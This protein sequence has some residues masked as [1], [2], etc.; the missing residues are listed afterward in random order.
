MS[1]CKLEPIHL[2]MT[3]LKWDLLSSSFILERPL[4]SGWSSSRSSDNAAA[5]L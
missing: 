5:G 2:T 4:V 3:F 1:A